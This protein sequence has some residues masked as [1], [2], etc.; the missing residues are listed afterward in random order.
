M[1]DWITINKKTSHQRALD[2]VEDL[3]NASS[4]F[5]GKYAS[6]EKKLFGLKKILK[7]I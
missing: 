4:D 2:K 5:T 7:E 6:F 1:H 3:K